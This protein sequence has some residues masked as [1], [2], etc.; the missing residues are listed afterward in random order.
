MCGETGLAIDLVAH[1]QQMGTVAH[2]TAAG[3]IKTATDRGADDKVVLSAQPIDQCGVG[4]KE[5][6]EEGGTLLFTKAL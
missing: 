5:G 4:R 2:Q 3:V 6:H 1:R